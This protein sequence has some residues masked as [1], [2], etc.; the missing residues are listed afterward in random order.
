MMSSIRSTDN[1]MM[2]RRS[3]PRICETYLF[4]AEATDDST[5]VLTLSGPDAIM[6]D[7][8]R[9]LTFT[10]IVAKEAVEHYG[11]DYGLNPL[12]FGSF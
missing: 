10:A 4:S 12:G 7:K 5:V 11:D 3:W 9:G 1:T 2:N 6:Y 8:A